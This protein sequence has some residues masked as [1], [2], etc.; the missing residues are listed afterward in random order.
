[1]GSR[2]SASAVWRVRRAGLQKQGAPAGNRAFSAAKAAASVTSAG[3][4]GPWITPRKLSTGACRIS[5]R[6]VAVFILADLA[7]L[8]C[9]QHKDCRLADLFGGAEHVAGLAADLQLG[10]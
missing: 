3:A 2:M 7:E 4:S 6:F 1:M 8:C 5:H 9:E 10:H